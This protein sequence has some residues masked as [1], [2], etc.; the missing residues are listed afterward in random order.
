[1]IDIGMW[2]RQRVEHYEIAGMGRGRPRGGTG[3]IG[4]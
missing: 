4:K 3:R 2:P 1:V